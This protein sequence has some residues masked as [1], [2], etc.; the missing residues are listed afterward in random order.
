M[1]CVPAR[2]TWSPYPLVQ[3]PGPPEKT[4]HPPR[5][6]PTNP[7]FFFKNPEKKSKKQ[8]KQLKKSFFPCQCWTDDWCFLGG[9][10]ELYCKVQKQ[11]YFLLWSGEKDKKNKNKHKSWLFPYIY[12]FLL[13]M[14]TPMVCHCL[15]PGGL[16][17]HW[18]P[19]ASCKLPASCLWVVWFIGVTLTGS[20]TDS[21]L[22]GAA[23]WHGR[24]Q[25]V[26]T[27]HTTQETTTVV[28]SL[29]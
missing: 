25:A 4:L 11:T 26:I 1:F 12:F 8:E 14:M 23:L 22:A 19:T 18:R 9:D 5:P 7:V 2:L 17:G 24:V 27:P 3:G 6:P 29:S 20:T 13:V 15:F 28:C 10:V 16:T 21:P